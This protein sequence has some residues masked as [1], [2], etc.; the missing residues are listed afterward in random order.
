M[1]EN[2][3]YCHVFVTKIK[4]RLFSHFSV[5]LT[6]GENELLATYSQNAILNNFEEYY[7]LLKQPSVGCILPSSYFVDTT[8][9]LVIALNE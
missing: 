8:Q 1:Q 9:C 5:I 2:A 7:T 3:S 4:F 6:I